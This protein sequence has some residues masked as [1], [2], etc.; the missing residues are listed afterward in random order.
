MKEKLFHLTKKDFL[1]ES[2]KGSG[3]GGQHRNKRET[4][5]RIKHLE[6]GAIG[7]CCDFK[8]QIKNKKIAFQR[9]INTDIFRQW[10]RIEASKHMGKQSPEQIVEKWMKRKQDFKIEVQENRQWKTVTEE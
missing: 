1:I 2:Y 6:S 7:Q 10:L 9:L 8:E 5:I 3:P 4:C